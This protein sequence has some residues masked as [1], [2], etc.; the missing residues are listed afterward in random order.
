M[1]IAPD[2][3]SAGPRPQ[4]P[5]LQ[6]TGAGLGLPSR[7]ALAGAAALPVHRLVQPRRV[8]RSARRAA[9]QRQPGGRAP[10]PV[11]A[12]VVRGAGCEREPAGDAPVRDLQRPVVAGLSQTGYPDRRARRAHAGA[13]P[14][15]Q[16]VFPARGPAPA[17]SGG[18]GPV[19]PVSAGGQQVAELHR[20][21]GGQG[22]LWARQR[23]RHRQGAARAAALHPHA[24]CGVRGAHPVRLALERDSLAPGGPVCRARG[25]AVLAVPGHPAFRPVGGR[26][27]CG[28]PAHRLAPGPGAPP[29]RPGRAA[30]GVGGLFRIPQQ[31]PA[32]P[33]RPAGAGAVPGARPGEPGPPHAAD[34][35]GGP[36]GV[37]VCALQGKLTRCS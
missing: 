33:V 23:D 37:A 20:A 3:N 2:S 8:L 18:A 26:G 11:H 4:H 9:P 35:P 29:F 15:G 17:D 34:R 30:R 1:P 16:G 6:R 5:R 32:A 19:A 7:G 12:G 13:A 27:G 10:G 25:R 21:P 14:L 36:A 22:C 28:E 31:F 24:R